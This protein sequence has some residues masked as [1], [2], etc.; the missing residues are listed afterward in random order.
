MFPIGR[1]PQGTDVYYSDSSSHSRP[2]YVNGL[3]SGQKYECV[4]YARRWHILNRGLTFRSVNNAMSLLTLPSMTDG[5]RR[6]PVF[7]VED[8][9]PQIG[10]LVIFRP[11]AANNHY[12]HVAVVVRV[13]G[14]RAYIGE[15]NYSPERWESD[16]SRSIPI[17]HG[18]LSDPDIIG[19]RRV[20]S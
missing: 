18:I 7:R 10:D 12:G 6:Y 17:V 11:S 5:A 4:E 8:Q 16:Y 14:S 3:Y 1:D 13:Q 19:V 15:Q 2:N 20:M 9:P